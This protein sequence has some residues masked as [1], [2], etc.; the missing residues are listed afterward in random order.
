LKISNLL[1]LYLY[2]KKHLSLPGFGIFTLNPEVLTPLENDKKNE[3]FFNHIHFEAKK[4]DKP[5]DDLIDFIRKHTGKMQPLAIADLERFVDVGKEMLNLDKVFHI[6]GIGNLARNPS[7]EIEF[8]AGN[9][10]SANFY[11]NIPDTT[12]N[13]PPLQP[14]GTA[15]NI[16][17]ALAI[18]I[19]LIAVIGGG[20]YYYQANKGEE[21]VVMDENETSPVT[22]TIENQ[23]DSLVQIV[24]PAAAATGSVQAISEQPKGYKFV[25]E[26][27]PRKSRALR[28]YEQ[29]KSYFLDIHMDALNDS[30]LF[31]LYFVIDAPA[32]DTN[33]IKDSLG[34]WY[35]SPMVTIE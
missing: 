25:I 21:M 15:R 33:Y 2:E 11:E 20:Y 30:T 24:A 8:I 19:G 6:E 1:A 26:T 29:L 18:L 14:D 16:A 22:D 32:K 27:T 3:D 7:G 4:V 23:A 5:D 34:R 35:N 31:K 12:E 28:R 10:S 17:V 9:S 13:L